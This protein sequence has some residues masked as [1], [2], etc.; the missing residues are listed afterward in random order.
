MSIIDELGRKVTAAG[1][2]AGQKTKDLTEVSRLNSAI[3]D[4]QKRVNSLYMQIGQKYVELH[5][6]NY[7]E[8]LAE[9]VKAVLNAQS[10]ISSAQE[11]IYMLKGVRICKVCGEQVAR[12]AAF[13]SKCGSP[14]P[15]ELKED[16]LKCSCG[17]PL[18]PDAKFCTKCGRPVAA[19]EAPR[20]VV[21]GEKPDAAVQLDVG[22]VESQATTER[23]LVN[24]VATDLSGLTTP[25]IESVQT[26]S[27]CGAE[28]P[29][30]YMFCNSCGAQM[31]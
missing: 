31:S 20:P 5:S 24:D 19:P 21:A 30:G 7:E 14:L 4:E 22:E 1:Q 11:Q 6:D 17:A 15:P 3:S 25:N 27:E 23:D 26:C 9:M 8:A 28:V 12:N 18:K 16:I 13:C 29:A 2:K 10:T